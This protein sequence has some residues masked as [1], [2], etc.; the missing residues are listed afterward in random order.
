MK[1]GDHVI[2]RAV[3]R[4]RGRR[5]LVVDEVS[6]EQGFLLP[7]KVFFVNIIYQCSIVIHFSIAYDT[8]E[9]LFSF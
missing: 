6:L 9:L 2:A 1:Q 7:F 4:L 3:S 5:E 8:L